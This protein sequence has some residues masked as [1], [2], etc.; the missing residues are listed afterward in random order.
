MA[1]RRQ[2]RAHAA[3]LGHA[4]QVP[5]RLS[6]YAGVSKRNERR[7]ASARTRSAH[8]QFLRRA[9]N[10]VR[11]RCVQTTRELRRRNLAP[12]LQN[13]KASIK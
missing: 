8:C 10:P 12:T 11:W 2:R 1:P 4:A 9:V 3:H 5:Q 13:C 7:H 6:W